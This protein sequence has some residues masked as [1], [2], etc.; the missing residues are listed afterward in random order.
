MSHRQRQE[1][2]N[3]RSIFFE[4]KRFTSKDG[5][6]VFPGYKCGPLFDKHSAVPTS[7][8]DLQEK[9]LSTLSAKK[10]FDSQCNTDLIVRYMKEMTNTD[11]LAVHNLPTNTFGQLTEIFACGDKKKTNTASDEHRLSHKRAVADILYSLKGMAIE[12]VWVSV[13][14][15]PG[16]RDVVRAELSK[17]PDPMNGK[18]C[19]WSNRLLTEKADREFTKQSMQADVVGQYLMQT[20]RYSAM[21]SIL[22]NSFRSHKPYFIVGNE[23]PVEVNAIM[24]LKRAAVV[25][26]YGYSIEK[27][28]EKGQIFGGTWY[29]PSL[30]SMCGFI[31][32]PKSFVGMVDEIV[33]NKGG[34]TSLS[35]LIKDLNKCL[36]GDICATDIVWLI[37]H[38]SK[39]TKDMVVGPDTHWMFALNWDESTSTAKRPQD[40][41]FNRLNLQQDHFSRSLSKCEEVNE[42]V[43]MKQPIWFLQ[44]TLI[45]YPYQ[46]NLRC[47]ENITNAC[48][49]RFVDE[50]E[51]NV[52]VRTCHALS[53][54][55][56]A[57]LTGMT[58]AV[59]LPEITMQSEDDWLSQHK[60][61]HVFDEGIL[62]ARKDL[63]DHMKEFISLHYALMT[64]LSEMKVSF[65]TYKTSLLRHHLPRDSD[66]DREEREDM[67]WERL[68]TREKNRLEAF[69]RFVAYQLTMILPSRDIER[70]LVS[71]IKAISNQLGVNRRLNKTKEKIRDAASSG[72][73]VGSIL[74]ED[75]DRELAK[76]GTNL[77]TLSSDI[78][79]QIIN[80]LP[81]GDNEQYFQIILAMEAARQKHD[82]MSTHM[83]MKSYEDSM[84]KHGY[85]PSD[86]IC[87][88]PK[89]DG[90]SWK[91]KMS[92]SADDD[93]EQKFS[94]A[95]KRRCSRQVDDMDDEDG[96]GGAGA[97]TGQDS[98]HRVLKHFGRAV[99]EQE[100]LDGTILSEKGFDLMMETSQRDDRTKIDT[101]HITVPEEA[102]KFMCGQKMLPGSD[103]VQVGKGSMPAIKT[104]DLVDPCTI[105][106]ILNDH[107]DMLYYLLCLMK[108]DNFN[109]HTSIYQLLR[110]MSRAFVNVLNIMFALSHVGNEKCISALDKAMKVVSTRHD[111][112]MKFWR[113]VWELFLSSVT[114]LNQHAAAGMISSWFT[115]RMSI[116]GDASMTPATMLPR[117]DYEVDPAMELPMLEEFVKFLTTPCES[118]MVS[119]SCVPTHHS[120]SRLKV[121]QRAL[122][123]KIKSSF[124]KEVS[125]C[126]RGS[127]SS[128]PQLIILPKHRRVSKANLKQALPPQ[129]PSTLKQT[130]LIH[131]KPLKDLICH[132]SK[133]N[134]QRCMDSTPSH[135][136]S[137]KDADKY[138]RE[139]VKFQAMECSICLDDFGSRP[140]EGLNCVYLTLERKFRSERQIEDYVQIQNSPVLQKDYDSYVYDHIDEAQRDMSH[141][142]ANGMHLFHRE[143]LRRYIQL[144]TLEIMEKGTHVQGG[145]G[146][147]S[148]SESPEIKC[149]F[150]RTVV[151][152]WNKIKVIDHNIHEISRRLALFANDTKMATITTD[153]LINMKTTTLLSQNNPL[154][155]YFP[156]KIAYSDAPEDN[157]FLEETGEKYTSHDDDVCDSKM[158]HQAFERYRRIVINSKR[159]DFLPQHA[160]KLIEI[161]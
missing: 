142:K 128:K 139:V 131:H 93:D 134:K 115:V 138:D 69:E 111:E 20:T 143:C 129:V 56:A 145:K 14:A 30:S 64:A 118:E 29:D 79:G 19:D 71:W 66:A 68:T 1:L 42:A 97:L 54:R 3:R 120:T 77:G 152:G 58:K 158:K 112:P 113:N 106:V 132:K 11:G 40:L 32:V 157:M 99:M 95:R 25:C 39:A 127:S 153:D 108:N 16:F 151:F 28:R 107:R 81:A 100:Q 63:G 98:P 51:R 117:Y 12:C 123:K 90:D 50:R 31:R 84:T 149:P 52:H 83:V 86:L 44:K 5:E 2:R 80:K 150:C 49:R 133:K 72:A 156:P 4:E 46:C 96:E 121:D 48:P 10:P 6:S 61:K 87:D 47:M 136:L 122:L 34:M 126:M 91:R 104:L 23:H 144:E 89:V 146:T 76:L 114:F 135:S 15:D 82:T 67:A 9:C 45:M 53:E 94:Y 59:G 154:M 116:H 159:E 22:L 160:V 85:S 27:I 55:D 60:L 103:I 17:Y 110:R 21:M 109:N 130:P 125:D 124:D 7:W 101:R 74:M 57:L 37:R 140:L 70:Y 105:H 35:S 38:V 75:H 155:R 18:D 65:R 102:R 8:A 119:L 147:D 88:R 137:D 148:P 41:E 141:D 13:F 92:P 73:M 26:S 24:R 78:C 36:P 62:T 43:V 33:T 161:F